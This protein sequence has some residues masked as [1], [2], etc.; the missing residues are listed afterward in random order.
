MVMTKA[1]KE[2]ARRRAK[3]MPRAANVKFVKR[4]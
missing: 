1:D 4:R 3:M 2:R